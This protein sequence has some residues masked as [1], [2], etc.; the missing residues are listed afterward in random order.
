M[1]DLSGGLTLRPQTPGELLVDDRRKT[2]QRWALATGS[3]VIP[4]A[5]VLFSLPFHGGLWLLLALAGGVAASL[6]LVELGARDDAGGEATVVE[7]RP[8][9]G[10]R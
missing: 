6:V 1:A 4:V 5:V 2:K 3:V 7:L 8:R 10:E 9:D